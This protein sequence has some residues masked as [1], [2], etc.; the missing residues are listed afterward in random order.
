[1]Q[2]QNDDL[3]QFLP[4]GAIM[5]VAKACN[6]SHVYVAALAKRPRTRTLAQATI[7][8]ALRQKA[9]DYQKTLQKIEQNS[10]KANDR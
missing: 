10:Q 5:E 9:D 7:V 2:A 6:A 1:M 4:Y 3:S 8:H